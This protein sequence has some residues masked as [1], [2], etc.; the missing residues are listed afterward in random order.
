MKK[1]N[2]IDYIVD[3]RKRLNLGSEIPEELSQKRALVLAT[4][5]DLN[6]ESEPIT[7]VI[8]LMDDSDNI[9][10]S[11]TFINKLQ[12]DYG[13][14]ESSCE[15]KFQWNYTFHLLQYKPEWIDSAYK[16]GK[17]LYDCG[18]YDSSI[19]YLYFCLAVMQPTDKVTTH[20]ADHH[21]MFNTFWLLEL[22]KRIMGSVG[23]CNS[24]SQLGVG[25]G[26]LEPIT[27]VYWQQ[28]LYVSVHCFLAPPSNAISKM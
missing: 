7:K 3:I 22:P 12:K 2:L 26:I 1:T 27:R 20:N 14:S 24:Y 11:A 9:K 13:V 5:Q 25:F 18:R 10:D 8:D 17:Y 4:L 21:L 28:Q 15:I 16:I 19:S 23:R 6:V